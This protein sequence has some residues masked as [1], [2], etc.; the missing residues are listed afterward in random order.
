MAEDWVE[1]RDKAVLN[2]VYYCETCNV[3]VELG[4]A[5]ISIHKKDLPHHKMRRVMI[6]RCGQCG[7]VVTDSYAEYSSE[8]NQ[9]WCKNCISEAGAE[10]FHSPS[11]P[12]IVETGKPG[13]SQGAVSLN[14][15]LVRK[16]IPVTS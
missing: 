1:A 7:N 13:T 10:A 3:I 11:T 15:D 9:F 8:K 14:I 12:F 4:D 16:E 2:T 6:L 5:D